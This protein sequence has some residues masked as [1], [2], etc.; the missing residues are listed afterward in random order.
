[1]NVQQRT[2]LGVTVALHV[3]VLAALLSYAPAR[4]AL[5]DA[6]PLMV[7]LIAPP[8]A[9]EP[10]PAPPTELPKPK[11]AHH[12]VK[13]VPPPPA[14]VV[15]A[16]VEAPSPIVTAPPP[17]AP[18]PPPA[19]AAPALLPV[20]PPDYSAA[21]LN[22][23]APAYPPMAKRLREQG[24]VVLRVHVTAA[25]GVDEIQ[26]RSSS[27]STRLDEAALEAVRRW[28]FAPAKHGAESVA[29]W[30]LVPIPFVLIG[31]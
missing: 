18:P 28:K 19:Q 30:V 24:R 6:A 27:G 16:P 25:G 5:I 20:V 12:H 29:A 23:P 3:L 10:T 15:T 9:E 21:Y 4:Q 22:N 26:V 14:P 31:S 11:P 2:G 17:A 13:P 1:M 7:R 8:K